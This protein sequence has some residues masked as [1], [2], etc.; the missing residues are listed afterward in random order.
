[1]TNAP[2]R[3]GVAPVGD[4][5]YECRGQLSIYIYPLGYHSWQ[6]TQAEYWSAYSNRTDRNGHKGG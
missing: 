3:D 2:F 1:M 4:E 5:P 6:N